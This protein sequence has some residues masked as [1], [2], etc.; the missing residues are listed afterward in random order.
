MCGILGWC[1]YREK[2]S[3][4]SLRRGSEF[5]KSRGPDAIGEFI[6]NEVNLIHTR[7]SII[8]I[9]DRSNQPFKNDKSGN[10]ISYNGEIYNFKY[11]KEDLENN[12]NV[13]FRTKSDTEVVLM[14]YEIYGISNLLSKLDGMFA[15]AIWDNKKKILIL[16]RDK[17]GEKPLFY[18]NDNTNGLIF[19]S[20][21]SSLL[22]LLDDDQKK[23]SHESLY[24]YLNLSYLIGS[25]TFFS[26]IKQLA[27][28]SYLV[29]DQNTNFEKLKIK[30]YWKL[31]NL[32]LQKKINYNLKDATSIFDELFLKSVNKRM[33]SDIKPGAFLSG[34][35]D[36][37][38]VNL[39]MSKKLKS[40]FISH[41]L[42]FLQKNFD[43]SQ[44]A[45]KLAKNCGIEFFSY[46]I[47]D[48][49][50]V[51]LDFEKI[52]M[53]M[54]Q[55]LADTAFISN[56]YLSKN[57]SDK[58]KVILSG[59][60]G[61]ELFGGYETYTADYLKKFVNYF[62][63]FFIKLI[64]NNFILKFNS[65]YKKKISLTYKLKKFFY[66]N[67]FRDEHAHIL[68]RAIFDSSE[69]YQFTL[70]QI[71][72]YSSNFFKEISQEYELVKNSNRIDKNIFLDLKTWFPNN[73]LN[74]LDRSSMFHS[75]ELRLPFLDP[76]I[77]NFSFSLEPHIKMKM[78]Q[79]KII[80]KNSL[81]KKM[82]KK[83]VTRKKAG[84]N[85]PIGHWIAEDK[86]FSELTY[87]LLG[88]NFIKALVKKEYIDDLMRKHK[89]CIEDNSFK[90][91]N[92]IVLSQW[93]KN[94][95]IN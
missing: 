37:S 23:L 67:H 81:Q 74:K 60:G 20:N 18:V 54:D 17:F 82:G 7:L 59:D 85:T 2:K 64:N 34:G 39:N 21:V 36:S 84:F 90:I 1:N 68:W 30:K 72:K 77:I 24:N 65:S 83:F 25:K 19:S 87:S 91:F 47:P 48:A 3:I 86:N 53:A 8:D 61:D 40:S 55:P 33:I 56:Y 50:Q 42:K 66:Y 89:N 71:Q 4:E 94:K 93:I 62:P 22:A 69:I 31:E 14:G 63:D 27:P 92:L 49:K 6:G 58:S 16:A 10:I 13:K 41:N 73:I 35:V 44:Y 70:D 46:E 79:K 57:S 80:L 51:A 88:T 15:F 29:F 26:E 38:L 45:K 32:V 43:E 78:F 11:L 28:S 75:Q 52:V 5:I 9:N 76:E 12:F 95:N